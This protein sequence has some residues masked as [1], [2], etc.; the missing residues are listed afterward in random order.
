[1]EAGKRIMIF[2]NAALRTFLIAMVPVVELRGAIPVG[3]AGGLPYW[4]AVALSILGNLLPVP[5]LIIFARRVLR[6]LAAHF[7][8]M[9]R[10]TDFVETRAVAKAEKIKGYQLLGLMLFVAIPLPGTGAWTGSLVAAVL[11][12]PTKKAVPFIFLGLVIAAAIVTA[13]SYSA[14][15]LLT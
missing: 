9:R 13:V 3:L 14:I 15:A 11:E 5:F 10:F 1:M 6:W 2:S 8:F 7:R 12:L 4:E